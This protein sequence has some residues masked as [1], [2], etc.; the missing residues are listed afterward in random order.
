MAEE[1][2]GPRYAPYTAP[3][4]PF[5]IG[6]AALDPSRWIDVAGDLDAYLDEKRRLLAAH[7]AQVWQEIEGSTAAQQEALDLVLD[8]LLTDHAALYRRSGTLVEVSDRK[9]DL[10]DGT[11]PAL[12]KAG[13]LIADDLVVLEKK[14]AGWTITAGFVAFPSGWS[15]PEKAGLPMEG[16]HAH[17]PGFQAGTRNATL[18]NRIFDNLRPDLPAIRFN[19]SIYPEGELYWPP[20]RG[21]RADRENPL[22]RNHFIRIERQTLRRLPR[23][24]AILFTIRIDQDPLGLLRRPGNSALANALA[25]KLRELTQEQLAYKGMTARRDA[26]LAYLEAAADDPAP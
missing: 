21:A 5:S 13:F 11:I 15:L 1:G 7:P 2:S 6:L 18:V 4:K 16:V 26:L 12:Q 24:G 8:H 25:A 17:V 10:A 23:T 14:D 20:E 22:A 3:L 19:W 9:V